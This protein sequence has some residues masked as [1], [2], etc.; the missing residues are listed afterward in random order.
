M[1]KIF[2]IIHYCKICGKLKFRDIIFV[3][4]KPMC[5]KCFDLNFEMSKE[6]EYIRKPQRF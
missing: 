6:G 1:N 2:D 3:K 5:F 4:G